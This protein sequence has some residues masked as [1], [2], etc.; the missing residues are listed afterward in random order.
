MPAVLRVAL[1]VPLPQ[2]FD[3]LP[4]A[5]GAAQVGARIVVPWG[6]KRLLGVV[7]A[8]EATSEVA[9]TR[10]KQAISLPDAEPL[11]GVELMRTLAWAADYWLAAPGEAYANALPVA[12]R[13]ARPLPAIGQACWSLTATGA[14]ALAA[15]TRRG[16]SQAL[17][18]ALQ[19]GPASTRDLNSTLPTWRDAARRLAHAG[20]IVRSEQ[21]PVAPAHATSAAPILSREQAHAVAQIGASLGQY[22]PFLLDGVTGSGKT[23]VYLA[24]IEQVLARGQQALLLVPEIG[25][26]PQ[27][28]ARLRAR[29]GVAVEVLHS[30]L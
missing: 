1:P 25:L 12:L 5:N 3:Y 2:L 13:S 22:Q 30:N 26:A 21:M 7:V 27:T 10:L 23:E 9:D 8:I 20:L 29:L 24:L 16:A 11:L 17:L 15:G 19:A 14:T 6:R 18:V 4:T 28:V